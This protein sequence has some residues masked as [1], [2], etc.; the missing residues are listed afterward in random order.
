MHTFFQMINNL[1]TALF[2]S[3]TSVAVIVT[4]LNTMHIP[5]PMTYKTPEATG[6]RH[7]TDTYL[8]KYNE[9]T[10][11]IFYELRNSTDL[12]LDQVS[13]IIQNCFNLTTSIYYS[14]TTTAA[15]YV[16]LFQLSYSKGYF[17]IA[18][19]QRGLVFQHPYMMTQYSLI[20]AY[21]QEEDMILV[22]DVNRYQYPPVWMRTGLM[23]NAMN[24][25]SGA[26]GLLVVQGPAFGGD[27]SF[28]CP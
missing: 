21:N 26:L 18:D 12:A 20:V 4:A 23:I 27:V 2:P 10:M 5:Q 7:F 11:S 15:Q 13:R 16:S 24:T 14:N 8:Y 22:L 6:L 19:Y 28:S 25:V 1:E 9:C 3:E 17:L